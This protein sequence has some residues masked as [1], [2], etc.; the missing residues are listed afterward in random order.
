MEVVSSVIVGRAAAC[1][2]C[3]DDTKLSRQHFAIEYEQGFLFLTDLQSKNGTML[4]G[5]R[6][7]S[8][9]KLTSGDKI[10]AGLSDMVIRF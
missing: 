5:I 8:R 4:N 7:G 6:I 9:Q 10:F 2:I 3:I 1:D